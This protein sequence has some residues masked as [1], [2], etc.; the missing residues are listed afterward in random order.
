[1]IGNGNEYSTIIYGLL[2]EWLEERQL[3]SNVMKV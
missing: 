3:S 1:M 2:T